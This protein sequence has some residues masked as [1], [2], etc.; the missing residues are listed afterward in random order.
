VSALI[1]VFLTWR[2]VFVTFALAGF[3][4]AFLVARRP[5]PERAAAADTDAASG[6]DQ[7]LYGLVEDAHVEP[8]ATTVLHGDQRDRSIW[9]AF[10]YTLRVRTVVIVIVAGSLG[11]FFFSGLQVFAV[12]FAVDEFGIPQAS[13][14]LL[15]PVV[16][17]G[18]ALGLLGGGR[19][20]DALIERG[21][22]TGR[23]QVALWSFPS[24]CLVIL[25]ALFLHSVVIALPFL[26][27]GSAL[28]T[29]PNAPLDAVRLDV[30]N[31][32]LR[33]RAESVRSLCRLTAQAAGPLAFGWL[34][35]HL[36]GGGVDGVRDAFLVTVPLLAASGFVLLFAIR[37]YPAD[38]AAVAASRG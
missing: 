2:G 31:P 1:V 27:I 13:A 7:M 36:A 29:A 17:A 9:W 4:I 16:G 10:R 8:R 12:V 6:R 33:G 30:V 37:T 35:D 22:I 18:A 38:V 15:I 19:V 5:E 3:V 24:A 14:A 21:H 23:V 28:L 32:W 11:D 20:G 26:V 25:P 34:A